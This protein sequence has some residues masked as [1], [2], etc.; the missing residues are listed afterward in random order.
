MAAVRPSCSD[1]YCFSTGAST[2]LP[3]PKCRMQ[4][5]WVWVLMEHCC[6]HLLQVLLHGGLARHHQEVVL[7]RFIPT[8]TMAHYHYTHL[9]LTLRR[10]FATAAAAVPRPAPRPAPTPTAFFRFSLAGPTHTRQ[11]APLDQNPQRRERVVRAGLLPT[12]KQLKRPRL[13]LE[14]PKRRQQRIT[15]P[16]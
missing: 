3:K 11:E 4:A 2:R 16:G 9:Q 10:H 1:I 15:R 14:Q 8:T 12:S 13:L 5:T 7:A 6:R